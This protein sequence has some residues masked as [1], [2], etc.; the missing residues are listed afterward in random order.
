MKRFSFAATFALAVLGVL[1]LARS[2][3]AGEQVPFNGTLEGSFTV[4]PVPPPEIN[5]QLD[6]TGNATQLGHFTYDFPHS[7]DRSVMP[8]T[9]DRPGGA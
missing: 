8:A 7:V 5:R 6:A 3:A 2:S 1:G 9:G 4:I